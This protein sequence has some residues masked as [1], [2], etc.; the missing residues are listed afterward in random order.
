LDP[1]RLYQAHKAD[2]QALSN[3][4]DQAERELSQLSPAD[5]DD[6]GRLYRIATSD[7]ALAKR[8]FPRHPVAAFLNQ[9]VARGHAVLY[10]AEPL[11]L[12][13]IWRFM[14]AGFP[15]V[16]RET[17]PFILAATLLFFV[18][19]LLAGAAIW[20]EP[21][22]SRYLLPP[23]VA[24][25]H[26]MIARGELWTEIPV[27]ERPYTSSF[28][29]RNNL[30]VAFLAFG[31]GILA[32][33]YTVWIM[34]Y[35]GLIIGG[36]TGLTAHYGL[37]F[38]LWTFVIGHGVIELSVIT[39]AGG[40]GLML[41]WAILKPGLLRRQD[42]LRLAAGRAVRLV[43]GCIP[44]LVLAGLIEGFISPNENIPW[45][46]KW[47]VGLGS[48]G[49]LYAYLLLAGRSGGDGEVQR[50]SDRQQRL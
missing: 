3:L 16:Y 30:Q 8:D 11:A 35:N 27:N 6:L 49:L 24:D 2:W 26:E 22:A 40:M 43:I 29:M 12:R 14:T 48:G 47:A 44:L 5:V 39:M 45:L 4:L 25:L 15:Q 42:A 34:V 38:D 10:R 28:I 46:L 17:L 41:G 21:S 23:Q 1:N 37:G 19:A 50:A 7:L 13:R 9:L 31:S 33:L 18:P 36:L 32:G 20:I